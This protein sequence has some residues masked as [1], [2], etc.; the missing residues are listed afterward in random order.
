M[1]IHEVIL[2]PK[3]PLTSAGDYP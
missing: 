2:I 1:Q 3:F